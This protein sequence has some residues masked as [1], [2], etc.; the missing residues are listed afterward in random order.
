VEGTGSYGAGLTRYLHRCG[1][2]VVE[3]DRPD[4]AGRRKH[5]KSDPPSGWWRRWRHG[6]FP[7]T[8]WR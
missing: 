4:R 7:W 6:D 1:V 3:V 5:G 2:A 8:P